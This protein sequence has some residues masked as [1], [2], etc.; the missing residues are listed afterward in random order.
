MNAGVGVNEDAFGGKALGA[1]TRDG[2]DVVEMAMLVK[3]EFDTSIIAEA[4]ERP[5]IE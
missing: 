4:D 5:T 2:V 1:A 3:V